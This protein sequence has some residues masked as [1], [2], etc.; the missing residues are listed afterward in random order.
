MA[1]LFCGEK[2]M[3]WILNLI[4]FYNNPS[5][6]SQRIWLSVISLI[7][8]AIAVYMGLYQWGVV[9]HVW[10]PFFGDQTERVLSSYVSDL[11]RTWIRLPDAILGAITY[12]GD[13]IFAMAGSSSRW[14]DRPWLVILFGLYVIPPAAVSIILVVIQGGVIDTWCFLCLITAFVSVFLIALSC[15]E[16]WV[17][18]RFLTRLWKTKDR[19]LFWNT[20]WGRPSEAAYAISLDLER[21]FT[22]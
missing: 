1:P 14:R 6:W 13:I 10:D 17:T 12:L 22:N 2:K 8:T 5:R 21:K 15:N 20:F 9:D 11:I 18:L 16:T 4:G 3:N 19:K 7:A